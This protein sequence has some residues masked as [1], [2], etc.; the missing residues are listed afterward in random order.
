MNVYMPFTVNHGACEV[1][2]LLWENPDHDAA[3]GIKTIELDVASYS[4]LLVATA[5]SNGYLSWNILYSGATSVQRLRNAETPLYYRE[6]RLSDDIM[7]ISN[8]YHDTSGSQT[9]AT[10]TR[11]VPHYIYGIR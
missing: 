2:E 9:G 1:C 5:N 11:V 7:Q 6:V 10:T 4:I 8:A 3:F